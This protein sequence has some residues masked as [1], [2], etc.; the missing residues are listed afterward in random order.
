MCENVVDVETHT[1]DIRI[2]NWG[3]GNDR[4]HDIFLEGLN[5]HT[6]I[7]GDWYIGHTSVRRGGNSAQIIYVVVGGVGRHCRHYV[8]YDLYHIEY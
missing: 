2:I 1:L 4:V 5:T 7:T 3:S 6:I 8:I